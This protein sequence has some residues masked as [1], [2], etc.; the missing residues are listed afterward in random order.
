MR[1]GPGAGQRCNKGK[2]THWPSF[3]LTSCGELEPPSGE[4][5]QMRQGA[6]GGQANHGQRQEEPRASPD[7][8]ILACGASG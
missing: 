6:G 1:S 8:A 7:V 5:R 3:V 4:A 2:K